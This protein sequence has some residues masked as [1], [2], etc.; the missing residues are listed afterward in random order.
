MG[1]V[2]LFM[3]DT[4][5]MLWEFNAGK[6][7]FSSVASAEGRYVIGCVDGA[8]YSIERDGKKVTDSKR[9]V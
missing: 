6:P 1:F 4:G 7:I 3:Q 9:A 8:V 2:F 5:D